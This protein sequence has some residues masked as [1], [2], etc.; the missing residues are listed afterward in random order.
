MACDLIVPS[1]DIENGARK[2]DDEH[3]VENGE[4]G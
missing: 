4:W 3:E 1:T 2:E